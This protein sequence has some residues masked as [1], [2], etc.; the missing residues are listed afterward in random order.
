[1][2]EPATH[3]VSASSSCAADDS[4]LPGF[5]A[6]ALYELWNLPES[7]GNERGFRIVHIPVSAQQ[8]VW[9]LQVPPCENRAWRP[10]LE[11][12]NHHVVIRLWKSSGT[13]WNCN[14]AST[15]KIQQLALSEVT[16][17]RIAHRL[18]SSELRIPR[19]LHFEATPQPWAIFECV[20]PYSKQGISWDTSFLDSMIHV[21][22][23]FGFDEPHP[24]WGRLPVESCE[25]YGDLLLQ[26]VVIPLHRQWQSQSHKDATG[27]FGFA[28]ENSTPGL[29]YSDMMQTYQQLLND[30]LLPNFSRQT[31]F[32]QN[33]ITSLQ[34][35]VK[36]L[37]MEAAKHG[38]MKVQGSS[39]SPFCVPC[40][41]DLQ[42]QN[43]MFVSSNLAAQPKIL[44]VLD[45]E[46]AAYAD[47]RFEL[48]MIGRKVMAHRQQAD[49][50]WNSYEEIM[51]I[52]LG[53]IEPWLRLE[54]THSLVSLLLQVVAGGGKKSWEQL[55]DIEQKIVREFKRLEG[56]GWELCSNIQNEI[57]LISRIVSE[58]R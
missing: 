6:K 22:H 5:I 20:G 38:L 13:W 54:T 42:P 33:A 49:R 19:V 24:R 7:T 45:W 30:V 48:L 14:T 27:L 25:Q 17:Y 47:C 43:L 2:S 35:A 21:R 34:Q 23:E 57:L 4:N 15:Q 3:D 1:M 46:D 18:L 41:M 52:V 50:I 32:V 58:S 8:K 26:Q 56:L 55:P 36:R 9:I 12:G 10:A 28:K 16:A 11:E 44:S 39:I 37:E 51:G 29:L 31:P 53:P 40:H